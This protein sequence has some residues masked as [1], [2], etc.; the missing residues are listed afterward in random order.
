MSSAAAHIIIEAAAS[1]VWEKVSDFNGL[2]A[3][4]QGVESSMEGEGVGAV[5]TLKLPDGAVVKERLEAHDEDA[6]SLTYTILEGPLPVANYHSTM[7]VTAQGENSSKVDW[8]SEFDAVGAPEAAA[9]AGLEELYNG[10]LAGL[11]ELLS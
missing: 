6:M 8:T 2:G 10:G 1:A 3:F 5:R 7:K 4:V 11:K 9:V